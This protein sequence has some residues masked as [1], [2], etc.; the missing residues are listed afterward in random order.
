MIPHPTYW[1][2]HRQQ[3]QVAPMKLLKHRDGSGATN[4][5]FSHDRWDTNKDGSFFASS[6]H[7]VRSFFKKFENASI[8][9]DMGHLMGTKRK[10]VKVTWEAY[11]IGCEPHKFTNELSTYKSSRCTEWR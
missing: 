6:S 7:Q 11:A 10:Y 4:D 5:Y 3:L 9:I 2:L 8:L 1:V